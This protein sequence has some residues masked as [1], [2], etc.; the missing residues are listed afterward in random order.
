MFVYF[1]QDVETDPTIWG[2]R[3]I[4]NLSRA[5]VKLQEEKNELKQANLLSGVNRDNGVKSFHIKI[6]VQKT[7]R[8]C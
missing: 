1:S 4:Q 5:F 6:I 3:F 2:I 7:T 8:V